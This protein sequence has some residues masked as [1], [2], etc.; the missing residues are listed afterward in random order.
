MGDDNM[1]PQKYEHEVTIKYD[2]GS[3]TLTEDL[4]VVAILN[5]PFFKIRHRV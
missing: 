4:S 2:A 1:K 5:N 3:V